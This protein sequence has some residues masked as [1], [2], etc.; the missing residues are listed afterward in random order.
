[1][2]IQPSMLWNAAPHC[3]LLLDQAKN[4]WM[5][6]LSD[7]NSSM[8]KMQPQNHP[9]C[10]GFILCKLVHLIINKTIAGVNGQKEPSIGIANLDEGADRQVHSTQGH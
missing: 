6:Q 9:Q 8:Q 4:A 5:L 7:Q 1:M 2:Q 3:C 10:F